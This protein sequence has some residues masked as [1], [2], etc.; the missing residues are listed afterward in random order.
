VVETM[1][2]GIRAAENSIDSGTALKK[3]DSLREL[4]K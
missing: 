2:D 1:Q 3:L 4:S